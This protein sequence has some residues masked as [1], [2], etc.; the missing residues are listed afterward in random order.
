[1]GW[2]HQVNAFLVLRAGTA[3][4]VATSTSV[5]RVFA[6]SVLVGTRQQALAV[7]E[8]GPQRQCIPG[9]LP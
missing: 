5:L 4:F 9:V 8:A 6:E 2:G 3:P 7:A 1:M